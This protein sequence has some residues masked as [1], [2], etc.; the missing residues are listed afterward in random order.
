MMRSGVP[1]VLACS[2]AIFGMAMERGWIHLRFVPVAKAMKG[3]ETEPATCERFRLVPES[4][5]IPAILA[6]V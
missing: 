3:S 6:T 4:S 1:D 2:G 5:E